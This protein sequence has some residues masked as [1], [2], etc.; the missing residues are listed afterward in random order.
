MSQD[1]SKELEMEWISPAVVEMQHLKNNLFCKN[2]GAQILLCKN[3]GAQ[4]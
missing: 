3:L 1:I 2:L 4:Q